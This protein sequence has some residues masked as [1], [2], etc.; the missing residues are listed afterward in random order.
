MLNILSVSLVWTA[1]SAGAVPVRSHPASNCAWGAGRNWMFCFPWHSVFSAVWSALA[2]Q[3][4]YFCRSQTHT[5]KLHS[6]PNRSSGQSRGFLQIEQVLKSCIYWSLWEL[7]PH[8]KSCQGKSFPLSMQ[9]CLS[10]RTWEMWEEPRIK[11]ESI[12]LPY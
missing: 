4:G 1:T 10:I 6:S 5:W 9:I 7:A 3:P 8:R 11:I 2:Q 12:S